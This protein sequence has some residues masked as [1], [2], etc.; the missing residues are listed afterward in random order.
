MGIIICANY[1]FQLHESMG[2][3]VHDLEYGHIP[4]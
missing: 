4:I 1:H 2:M 3:A